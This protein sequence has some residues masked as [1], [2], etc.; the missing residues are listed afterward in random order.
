VMVGLGR[1]RLIS[2]KGDYN[3][4]CQAGQ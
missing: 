1:W 4:A 3:M 2:A